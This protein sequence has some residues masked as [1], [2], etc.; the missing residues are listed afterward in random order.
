MRSSRPQGAA[1]K[2]RGHHLRAG[3]IRVLSVTA[4]AAMACT[5]WAGAAPAATKHATTTTVSVSPTAQWVGGLVKLSATVR[6]AGR[7]PTGTVTIK[8]GTVK[9]CAG[10][11][12]K[13]HTSCNFIFARAGT[14]RVRAFYSGNATHKASASGIARATIRRSPTST[15]ITN[16][17][18]GSVHSGAAFTFHVTVTSRPNTPAVTG[19]V[20]VAPTNPAGLPFAQYGCNAKVTYG[21]GSCTIHPPAFGIV[22]YAATY[23]GSTAHTGSRYAGPFALAVENVTTTTVPVTSATAGA[24]TLTADVDSM[25]ANITDGTGSVAFYVGT[26]T[27]T[28]AVV[29]ECAAVP[30]ATFTAP[31]NVATC[32]N[33]ATLNALAAGTYTIRAVYSGDLVNVG[34][35]GNGSLTVGS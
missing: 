21:Q 13:G 1:S 6:S 27:A 16:A 19:T 4:M 15:K 5:L 32:T 22:D 23:G 8:W 12:S 18:P 20:R 10:H 7:V 17:N 2:P 3:A 35:T 26:S 33:S 28:L 31:N 30:L 34:S 29:P 11:L 24:V 14:Y 9:L 25:G